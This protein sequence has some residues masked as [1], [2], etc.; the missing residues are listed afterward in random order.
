MNIQWF[1]GHMQKTR[2]LINENLKLIDVVIEILDSRIPMSSKNPDIDELIKNKPRIIV[3]NKSDLADE[4]LSRLWNKWYNS[5]GY[6]S[7][8]ID[9][10]KGKGIK[11]LKAKLKNIMKE[12][13]IISIISQFFSNIIHLLAYYFLFLKLNPET[14]GIWTFLNSVINIGFLFINIG[15]DSIQYQYSGKEDSS[16]Y[17]GT[18]FFLKIIILMIHISFSIILISIV[19]ILQHT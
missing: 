12:K 4:N 6:T 16:D 10:L 2:R 18:Y 9:S 1:P 15:L 3:L 13:Y 5:K 11:E 7:I 14:M 19:I 8:F 17:F